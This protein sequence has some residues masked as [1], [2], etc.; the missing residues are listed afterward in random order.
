MEFPP[1]T[2]THSEE[3]AGVKVSLGK[4][5]VLGVGGGGCHRHEITKESGCDPKGDGKPLRRL[6]RGMR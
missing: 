4:S 1:P 6:S 3:A 2:H 5:W